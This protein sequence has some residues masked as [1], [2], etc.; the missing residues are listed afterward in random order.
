MSAYG[1]VLASS[2]VRPGTSLSALPAGCV[3]ETRFRSVELA[4]DGSVKAK[5]DPTAGMLSR[6]VAVAAKEVDRNL[7]VGDEIP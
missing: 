6:L 5:S 3:V 2:L 7:C 4:L 1:L